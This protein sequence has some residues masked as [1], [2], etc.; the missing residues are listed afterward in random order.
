MTN[1]VSEYVKN[2][3]AGT[4]CSDS[5]RSVD[6]ILESPGKSIHYLVDAL[7][8][9]LKTDVRTI[10]R[11]VFSAPS[12]LISSFPEN[13]AK[14]IK[15][16]LE[17][18]GA[19]ISIH[20]SGS[21]TTE[22]ETHFETAL[23]V[24]QVEYIPAILQQLAILIRLPVLNAQQLLFKSPILIMGNLS[25]ASAQSIKESFAGVHAQVLTSNTRL[26]LYDLYLGKEAA[27]L[28]NDLLNTLQQMGIS[29]SANAGNPN[30][31]LVASGLNRQQATDLWGKYNLAG[32]NF[33]I[34]NRD[35]YTFDLRWQGVSDNTK[36]TL[37]AKY[38][39]AEF[40]LPVKAFE[41][42]KTHKGFII[43]ENL[44][45]HD[46]ERHLTKLTS[47]GAQCTADQTTLQ[48]YNCIIKNSGKLESTIDAV[49]CIT[50]LKRS[51]I[52]QALKSPS[53]FLT[54]TASKLQ[55]SWL[56]YAIRQHG[57]SLEI[58]SDD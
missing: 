27:H 14:Q 35:F 38:L 8:P 52:R 18:M 39:D 56:R 1:Q 34:I 5:Q 47:L 6:L 24:N 12:V 31:P 3:A 57:G 51:K 36:D 7:L 33:R 40:G 54:H 32:D 45:I 17:E 20:P 30:Q 10:A 53:G 48:S 43:A 42:I 29:R 49:E 21:F 44:N 15:E 55:A 50:G 11:K 4:L 13:R 28:R 37:V 25:E 58:R 16:L 22:T 2:D 23:L 41:T 46:I 19:S 9:A 26:A